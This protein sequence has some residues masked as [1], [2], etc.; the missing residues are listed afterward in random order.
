MTH[1]IVA[2]LWVNDDRAQIL[3]PRSIQV[4]LTEAKEQEKDSICHKALTNKEMLLGTIARQ[5]FA[6]NISH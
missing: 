6:E 3:R 5:L 1:S 2:K 4:Q